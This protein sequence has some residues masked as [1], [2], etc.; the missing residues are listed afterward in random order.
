[1]RSGRNTAAETISALTLLSQV[2][3]SWWVIL[4]RAVGPL[5]SVYSVRETSFSS[6]DSPGPKVPDTA[7]VMETMRPR[8]SSSKIRT[9]RMPASLSNAPTLIEKLL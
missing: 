3:L 9:P 2:K 7:S 5:G 1:M 6:Q 4:A 8:L